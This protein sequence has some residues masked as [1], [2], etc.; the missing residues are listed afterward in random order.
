MN[1]PRF[2]GRG[3]TA[4][5]RAF[6][7]QL[8]DFFATQQ[9]LGGHNVVVDEFLGEGTQINIAALT[10]ACCHWYGC[11]EETFVQCMSDSNFPVWMGAGTRCADVDCPSYACCY[12]DADPDCFNA[13][14]PAMCEYYG[15]ASAGLG[16]T[17]DDCATSESVP[18]CGCCCFDGDCSY[19]WTQSDCEG[20]VGEFTEGLC[21]SP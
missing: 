4:V 20:S 6:W 17:C 14:D 3:S 7:D 15:F 10:G 8:S 19:P 9:K 2:R 21:C 18:P 16:T 13:A 11:A 5:R 1:V 12:C